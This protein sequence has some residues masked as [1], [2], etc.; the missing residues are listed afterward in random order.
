MQIA[1]DPHPEMNGITLL[2]THTDLENKWT[3]FRA[4]AG[5]CSR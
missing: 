2:P 4:C 1:G 3:K 5:T